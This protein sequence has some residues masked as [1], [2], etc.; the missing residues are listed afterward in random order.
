GGE[1]FAILRQRAVAAVNRAT[2]YQPAVLVVSHGALFRALRDAMGL[3]VN[4]RTPNAVP[5]WC[6]P[7]TREWSLKPV[8]GAVE[9]GT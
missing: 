1:P 5:I 8:H 4:Q 3:A 6:E 7:R 2:K 9:I